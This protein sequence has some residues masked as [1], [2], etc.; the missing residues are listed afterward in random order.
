MSE[1]TRAAPIGPAPGSRTAGYVLEEQIGRGGMA[2]VF[3]A[4][5][6]RLGRPGGA[7]DPDALAGGGRGVPQAVHPGV[8][9]GS[10]GGLG[11]PESVA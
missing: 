7:Q 2:V 8:S 6:E 10:R 1:E 9:R 3:R 11:E 5:D 4:R